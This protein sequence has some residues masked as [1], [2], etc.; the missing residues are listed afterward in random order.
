M[1]ASYKVLLFAALLL[2]S[3][4]SNAFSASFK[5]ALELVDGAQSQAA[6]VTAQITPPLADFI[7]QPSIG[8][9]VST[10]DIDIYCSFFGAPI[11]DCEIT[12]NPPVPA[13]PN[14]GGHN[15]SDSGRP[16]GKLEPLQGNSG[17]DAFLTVTYTAPDPAGVVRISGSGFHPTYGFFSGTFTIGIMVPGLSELPASSD[18][19]RIGIKPIHPQSHFG[20]SS[21]LASLTG[22]AQKYSE[23]FPSYKLAI[24]DISLPFGGLFDLDA[25][26]APDHISH[27][28]G[29]DADVHLVPADQREKL[30]RLIYRSGI[31]KIIVH[32]NHWHLRQ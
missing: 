2:S 4:S 17:S 16:L 19:D 20:T 14:T 11:P 22:L 13:E 21:M 10:I 27:R 25:N 31:S 7:V 6:P 24:N 1:H 9:Q 15:H 3:I 12:N 26:W 29:T 5:L 18:Y 23:A 32:S 8:G 30:R 28:L